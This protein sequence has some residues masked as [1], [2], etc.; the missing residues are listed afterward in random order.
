VT[1]FGDLEASVESSRPLEVYR[2]ASGGETFLY[3]SSEDPIVLGPD[4]YEPRPIA[5][6]RIVRGVDERRRNLTVTMPASDP[7]PRRYIGI[8]PGQRMVL[9]VIRLQRDESPTFDTQVAIFR[10]VV[11]SVAFKDDGLTAEIAVQ[12]ID[13]SNRVMPRHT[14]MAQCNHVLYGPGCDVDPSPFT[15]TG[16][17]TAVANNVLTVAGLGAARPD[18]FFRGGFAK[19]VAESDFRLVLSHQGD[20]LTLLL[21][22]A[23]SVL[24]AQVQVSAGCDHRF[25]GDCA[26]KFDNVAS[27]GGSP[28]VPTKN[29]FSTGLGL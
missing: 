1:S 26:N 6:S 8:P 28:Y 4:N 27:F 25:H 9:T 15:N 14:A 2:F 7:V 29:F 24:G 12:G 16:T 19:L 13:A 21:P 22:F 17:V 3:S 18:Q 11:K 23:A 10:G 5:R 20:D